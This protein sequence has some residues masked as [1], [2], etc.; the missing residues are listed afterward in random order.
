MKR[1]TN[2]A[3][4]RNAVALLEAEN[5]AAHN[6]LAL[7]VPGTQ[8]S[9]DALEYADATCKAYRAAAAKLYKAAR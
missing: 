8:E 9:F 5:L 6:A 7:T 3:A 2:L 4:L 1:T